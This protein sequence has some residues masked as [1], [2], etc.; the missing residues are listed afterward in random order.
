[1]S[2]ENP[3]I[4]DD[5]DDIAVAAPPSDCVDETNTAMKETFLEIMPHLTQQYAS[6]L[7]KNTNQNLQQALILALE[8][9]QE[10]RK[11]AARQ[12]QPN[13]DSSKIK[14][15]AVASLKTAPDEQDNHD[16]TTFAS[17]GK[18]WHSLYQ[19]ALASGYRL[20]RLDF[21]SN[22]RFARWTTTFSNH[23]SYR[24]RQVPMWSNSKVTY[25]PT[26][27]TKLWTILPILRSTGS[28]QKVFLFSMGSRRQ[29]RRDV[30]VFKPVMA[31]LSNTLGKGYRIT[32][33]TA[34]CRG[35]LLVPFRFGSDCGTAPPR[36]TSHSSYT[37][38]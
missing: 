18:E 1:M 19:A 27:W 33:C 14:N 21:P 12:N 28:R 11:V 8:E 31:F 23:H 22:L 34:G 3:I 37:T 17:L 16:T 32:S 6:Q 36:S 24:N 2:S 7:L 35:K 20:C 38:Q 10:Q 4:L 9:T 25:S 15:T 5:N 26:K 30:T 13:D 29:S